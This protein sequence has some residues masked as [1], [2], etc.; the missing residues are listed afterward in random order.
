[1]KQR[2]YFITLGILI[3]G[4]STALLVGARF[5]AKWAGG[6]G[7]LPQ[8]TAIVPAFDGNCATYE[9]GEIIS[10]FDLPEDAE[11]VCSKTPYHVL[12]DDATFINLDPRTEVKLID[13]RSGHIVI[14][15]IQGHITGSGNF[16]I[17]TR[18][19]RT[20]VNGGI[21]FTHY[22][23]ENK[24]EAVSTSGHFDISATD[25]PPPGI[26]GAEPP[27]GW[28]CHTITYSC[29]EILPN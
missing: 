2:T 4:I 29:E 6:E 11:G 26:A 22:S 10:T 16:T 20:S 25:A 14:D 1:M 27:N 24:T 28:R 17:Q 12:L 18:N 13:L 15:V 5:D 7:Y 9:R 19:M 8:Q 3:A 21:A 23:W